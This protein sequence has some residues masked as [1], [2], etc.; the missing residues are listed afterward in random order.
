VVDTGT[1]G[2]DAAADARDPSRLNE[3]VRAAAIEASACFDAFT[4]DEH[5]IDQVAEAGRLLAACLAQDGKVI[6]CGNGGS[7][8]D[9]I[10]LAEELTG[11]FRSDRRAL[12]ALALSDAGYLSCVGNDLGYDEVFARGVEALGRPGDVLVAFTTSGTSTNVIRAVSA[13]RR[14]GMV[15]IAVTGRPGAAVE[16][17][18]SLTI[19][20][21]GGRWADRVQEL[22]T[23]VVHALIELVEHSLG[24]HDE[25]LVGNVDR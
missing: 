12:G 18:A 11:R 3:I 6:T 5:A 20:T 2:A 14:N 19:V 1:S 17:E 7:M 9:A 15:A 25:S 22:H 23:L 21:P 10:H 8:C 13:A 24:I 16:Q 4:R